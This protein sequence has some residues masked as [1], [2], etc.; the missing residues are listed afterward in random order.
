ME[1]VAAFVVLFV[2]VGMAALVLTV[3]GMWRVFTKADKPGWGV[4]IPI[5]N[6]VL[7]LEIV[8]RPIWW[9]ILMFIPFVNL[10]ISIIVVLDMAKVFGKG[11]G[12]GV[13]LL[14][15][16][17]IFYPILGLGDA[18]YIGPGSAAVLEV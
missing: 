1:L 9:I 18:Q 12:F 10:V 2:L 5:Y 11:S 16:P 7:M 3:V 17:F 6:T 4:L 15:L 14:F 8:G 13:G